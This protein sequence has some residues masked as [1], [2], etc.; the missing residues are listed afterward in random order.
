MLSDDSPSVVST[1]NT[2]AFQK[3]PGRQTS[4]SSWL[5]KGVFFLNP[6]IYKLEKKKNHKWQQNNAFRASSGSIGRSLCV[7]KDGIKSQPRIILKEISL[8]FS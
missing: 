2:S 5:T 7:G 1:P 8:P 4:G 6:Q 3:G